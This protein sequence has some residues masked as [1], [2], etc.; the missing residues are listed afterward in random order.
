M[1]MTGSFEFKI[2]DETPALTAGMAGIAFKTT[3]HEPTVSGVIM[4]CS[5]PERKGD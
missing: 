2:F 4:P 3:N 1:G 5:E